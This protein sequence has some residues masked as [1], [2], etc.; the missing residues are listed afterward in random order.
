MLMRVNEY[1]AREK[2]QGDLNTPFIPVM[3]GGI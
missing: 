1:V 3:D 2:R